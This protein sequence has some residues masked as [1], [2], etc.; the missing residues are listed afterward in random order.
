MGARGARLWEE[1]GGDSLTG[2]RRVVLEE[3][4]R[5]VDR[6]DRLDAIVNGRDRAWLTL[7]TDDAGGITVVVDKLLSEGRQQQLALKQ[8][9]GE[10]RAGGGAAKPATGGSIL[11]Q[12]AARRATRL[13]NP[14]G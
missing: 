5:L 7:E 14:A 9:A 10:L 1:E 2:A 8:L 3:A 4:C 13:A 12:L 6:L 11:D